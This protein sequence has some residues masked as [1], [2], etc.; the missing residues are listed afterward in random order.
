MRR[1]LYLCLLLATPAFAD[2]R[3]ALGVGETFTYRVAWGIFS[4]AGEIKIATKP[5]T[6]DRQPCLLVVTTTSTRGFLRTVFPFDARAESVFNLRT[7]RMLAHTERSN[8]RRKPTDTML[9]FDYEHRTADYR[10]LVRPERSQVVALP[11]GDP[12]DLITSLVQ[13]R[14]WDLKPGGQIDILVM[15]EEEP[16]QLTF[17]AERYEEIRTALGTF[18][19]LVVVPRM[20]K[21]APKGMFKRGSTVRVWISQD[22][23]HLPVKFEVEFKFGKGVATLTKYEPPTPPNANPGP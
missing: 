20:E 21:T 6:D 12:M 5:E 17:H 11:A 4:G 14:S 3:L 2:T 13:A 16:Y 1:I 10:D 8:Q 22:E 7:G 19:T 18:Q 23:R 9:T 15:F